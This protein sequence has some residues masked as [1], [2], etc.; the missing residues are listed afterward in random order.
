VSVV[1]VV[2]SHP[3]DE[4]LGGGGTFA[5]H[6][7]AGDEVHAV[8]ISE[9]ATARYEDGMRS[10]LRS[11]A[12][13][14]GAVI[15]FS[16]IRFLSMPDQRLDATPLLE[17]TQALEPIIS[18]LKPQIVYTH[19]HVDVNADHGVVARATWT[20]CR[21]YAAPTVRRLLA[22]ET[23]SSTEWAW[24]TTES[25]F[26]PAWFVDV[27]ETLQRK[28]DALACYEPELRDYPHPRSLRALAERAAY[29]GSTVGARAI[30]P[31]V[32]LRNHA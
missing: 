16:S 26:Q 20:A 7:D 4:V 6:V 13:R 27:S 30:E 12:E 3:D 15:G 14:S 11:C 31:F 25:A 1:L 5:K 21:P 9:G 32:L 23:P 28:L 10:T 19:S 29:W 24:P 18:E 2:A 17:V 8:V 22:F